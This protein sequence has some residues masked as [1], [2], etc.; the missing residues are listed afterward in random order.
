M[1]EIKE[2]SLC[3]PETLR[4]ACI[5]NGWFTEGTINQYNKLFHA[6]AHGCTLG[7]IAAII[8]VCSDVEENSVSYADICEKLGHLW[9]EYIRR[10]ENEC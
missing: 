3:D 2:Y 6:N 7:E 8:W 1:K 4:Q 10:S 9:A 5:D